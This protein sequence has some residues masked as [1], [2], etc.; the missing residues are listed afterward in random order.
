MKSMLHMEW[1][2]IPAIPPVSSQGSAQSSVQVPG[3]EYGTA[4]GRNEGL[5]RTLLAGVSLR[6][7]LIPV[8]A[9]S[10][11]T[12]GITLPREAAGQCV[13]GPG[14]LGGI[15]L[16]T[17]CTPLSNPESVDV[18]AGTEVDNAAGAGL[19]SLLVGQIWDVEVYAGATLT[20]SSYGIELA[21]NSTIT[22]AGAIEGVSSGVHFPGGIYFQDPSTVYNSG[23]ISA[24]AGNAMYFGAGG[25]FFNDGGTV[26]GTGGS[27]VHMD[28]NAGYVRN[29]GSSGIYGDDYGIFLADNSYAGASGYAVF[30][31]AT[32]R[33]NGNYGL[34]V[35]GAA[36]GDIYNSGQ[37]YGREGGIRVSS[38]ISDVHVQNTG[39]ITAYQGRGIILVAAGQLSVYNGPAGL[40]MSQSGSA[41][42]TGT[43]AD[44]TIID[45]HGTISGNGG[46]HVGT[47]SSSPVGAPISVYNRADASIYG[48]GSGIY[49]DSVSSEIFNQGSIASALTA[50]WLPVGGYVLN[51]TSGTIVGEQNGIFALGAPRVNNAGSIAG[52]NGYGL[53]LFGNAQVTNSGNIEGANVGIVTTGTAEITNLA[54][55]QITGADGVRMTSDTGYLVNYGSITG[56]LGPGVRIHSGVITN[57]GIISGASG[58]IGASYAEDVTIINSGS[59]IGG[60]FFGA[61]NDS[62]DLLDGGFVEGNVDGGADVDAMTSMGDTE[63]RGAITNFET[64]VVTDGRFRL[65]DGISVIDQT[66]VGDGGVF[67]LDAR[68]IGSID[69]NIGGELQGNGI[70]EGPVMNAGLVAPG[71]S[72]GT[73][74]IDGD[75]TQMPTGALEAEFSSLAADQLDITGTA[76]LNGTLEILLQADSVGSLEG[77]TFTILIS[78]GGVV[79]QFDKD[80]IVEEGFWTVDIS[81]LGN[82]VD[83]T[84]LE[85][86]V[87]LG[88]SSSASG[89]FQSSLARAI[90]NTGGN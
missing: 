44:T 62:F 32:I 89:V 69:V 79:G 49:A 54:G 67:R 33:G 25:G 27:G 41:V 35:F 17:Y 77:K 19:Y 66:T 52:T 34:R 39:Q 29:T 42:V 83:A 1:D 12:A 82:Q 15:D 60:I 71:S 6:A 2:C 28:G 90:Q 9:V 4:V 10:V 75:F 58:G 30:N 85:V 22:N 64:L 74:T 11:V 21:G 37:I 45:N 47:W 59:V 46:T 38:V 70:A 18:V 16:A 73:L 43:T 53:N 26:I 78:D 5:R 31:S 80:G 23:T 76:N 68:L 87:P 72:I 86:N 88:I 8:F 20:G 61:G 55:G 7:F 84:F 14:A 3:A 13:I 57:Y 36:S 40:I 50:V 63:V 65:R 24:S 56:T 81:T 48:T 51:E